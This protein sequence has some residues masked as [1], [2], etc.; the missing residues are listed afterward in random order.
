M[1]Q[2]LTQ[3]YGTTSNPA[4]KITT[5]CAKMVRGSASIMQ[6]PDNITKNG[7]LRRH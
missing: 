4:S 3:K 2:P 6:A 7:D 5:L 1:K